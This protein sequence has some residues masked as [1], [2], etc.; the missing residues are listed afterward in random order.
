[1]SIERKKYYLKRFSKCQQGSVSILGLFIT[2]AVLGG[3]AAVYKKMINE[4]SETR[5]RLQT[6]LCFKHGL[7]KI[8]FSNNFI[9]TT[10][11][12]LG[13]LNAAKLIAPGPH[14]ETAR[15][16][17]QVSQYISYLSFVQSILFKK[18]CHL[19]NKNMLIS[20]YPYRLTSFKMLLRT[21]DGLAILKK[22]KKITFSFKFLSK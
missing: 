21:P 15:K 22:R 17:I 19:W 1:M 2:V 8:K 3:M 13:V 16:A 14:I 7:K 6:Y 4:N 10:N 11:A 5:E 12:S 9:F 20:K 18:E